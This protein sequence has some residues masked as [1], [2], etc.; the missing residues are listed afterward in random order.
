MISFQ[1]VGIN[2]GIWELNYY[3][4]SFYAL[5]ITYVADAVES[6]TAL[7]YII[8]DRILIF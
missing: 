4:D 1:L 3:Y 2:E 6:S 7:D 5:H 8:S